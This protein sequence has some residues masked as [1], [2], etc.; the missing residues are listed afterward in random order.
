MMIEKIRQYVKEQCK[1]ET[2]FFGMSAYNHHFVSVVKYAKQ[3]AQKTGADKEIVE[4]AAWLHDIGSILGDYEN[5]HLSG[6]IYAE[7][8]LTELNYPLDKIDKVKHCIVAHRGS[9]D[10]PR[11]TVEAKCVADAD[12]MSHF[13]NLSALFNLALVLRKKSI[14]DSK[15]FIKNKLERSWNKLTPQAKEIIR[16]KYEAMKIL[17]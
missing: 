3:L 9:K 14:D 4:I 16:P 1:K 6:A 13:D 8:L 10:I 5:H 11:E 2:N 15:E 17:L 7:K 12:A